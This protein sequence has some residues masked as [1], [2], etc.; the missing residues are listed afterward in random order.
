MLDQ[1][2]PSS[3]FTL[4][5]GAAT[6]LDP[7]LTPWVTPG[8][9]DTHHAQ[10]AEF[11]PGAQ[12]AEDAVAATHDSVAAR[13]GDLRKRPESVWVWEI[14]LARL[15]AEETVDE[16]ERLI[17]IGHPSM[18]ITANLHYA[19]LSDRDCRLRSVNERA[20]FL[21]ADGMPMVWY[22]RL[23]GQPLPE[24]V[25]GADL[26]CL[27]CERAAQRGHR[28]FLFGGAPGV[29][30][31]AAAELQRRYPGL[32][33]AGAAAPALG[34][35]SP[36]EH[37]ELLAE[38]HQARPHLLLVALGQPKG[39][40]WLAENLVATG[41][42][43][44][45]QVGASFDFVVGRLRRAPRWLQRIGLEWLYRMASEPRR[46]G[47]RYLNNGLFLLR[48]IVRDVWRRLTR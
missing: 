28:V 16:V 43:V 31:G 42:A 35:L 38:I 36:Q 6:A 44:S 4:P 15:T 46:L 23:L 22:S 34:Q 48:A 18:F 17:E 20:A 45:V 33:V 5:A 2:T 47:P 27:L 29:A 25:T 39:E 19:M 11:A 30:A 37:R 24:R 14:P 21:V 7:A 1:T 13:R 3:D 12:Q 9:D 8:P 32:I 10:P 40:L 26:V 41:A